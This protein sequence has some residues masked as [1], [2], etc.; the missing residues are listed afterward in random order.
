MT[1]L[2]LHS[3]PLC[4][5]GTLSTPEVISVV[6][7]KLPCLNRNL[8]R[9][10]KSYLRTLLLHREVYK[11]NDFALGIF[12][13]LF[14]HVLHKFHSYNRKEAS[15]YRR[16]LTFRRFFP[17]KQNNNSTEPEFGWDPVPI[18]LRWDWPGIILVSPFFSIFP[19]SIF[20]QALNHAHLI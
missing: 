7:I 19:A 2:D 9:L 12:S 18:T 4:W 20:L 17:D 8:Q 3:Y 16:G 1:P 14:N 10:P 15:G 5:N 13:S 6:L 11:Q